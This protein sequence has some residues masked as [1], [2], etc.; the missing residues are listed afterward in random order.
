MSNL[1]FRHDYYNYDVN[2]KYCRRIVRGWMLCWPNEQTVV[3]AMCLTQAHFCFLVFYID[4]LSNVFRRIYLFIC[5]Y[6][7]YTNRYII[8]LSYTRKYSTN[9]CIQQSQSKIEIA[10]LSIQFESKWFF[11]Y[12][13]LIIKQT[14]D[15]FFDFM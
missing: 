11:F 1:F 14:W 6:N 10:Y 8:R 13:K 2:T 3:G 12:W 7:R 5:I 15:M 4:L 9:R